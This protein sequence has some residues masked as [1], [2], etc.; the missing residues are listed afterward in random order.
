MY[1]RDAE[2]FYTDTSDSRSSNWDN[3]F[4]LGRW[5]GDRF[6][7]S[8]SPEEGNKFAEWSARETTDTV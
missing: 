5:G 3:F 4:S 6:T 8:P 1:K 2:N 7:L